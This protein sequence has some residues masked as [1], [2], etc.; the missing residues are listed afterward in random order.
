MENRREERLARERELKETL[1]LEAASRL[2]L[3]R[4]FDAVTMDELAAEA[5]FAKATLYRMFPSKLEVL[6][7]LGLQSIERAKNQALLLVADTSKSPEEILLLVLQELTQAFR[8]GSKLQP[9]G[10][11]TLM[12]EQILYSAESNFL[13]AIRDAADGY[14]TILSDLLTCCQKRGTVWSPL[15]GGTLFLLLHGF[16]RKVSVMRAFQERLGAPLGEE[17]VDRLTE[18]G[19]MA[20]LRSVFRPEILEKLMASFTPQEVL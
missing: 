6:C 2:F 16:L 5:G 9:S 1:I 12:L 10:A 17:Q 19:L 3:S 15:Q 20:L 4:G 13:R 11:S 18:E 8:A 14:I 7:R